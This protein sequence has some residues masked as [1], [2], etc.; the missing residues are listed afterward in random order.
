MD[1]LYLLCGATDKPFRDRE[2]R[3][4]LKHYHRT[5]SNMLNKLGS[6]ADKLFSFDDL[7]SQLK[8]FGKFAFVTGPLCIQLTLVN[9]NDVAN[10]DDIVQS[11]DT[12]ADFIAGFDAE[13]QIE[14]DKRINGLFSDLIE[15]GYFWK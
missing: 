2:Y 5:L 3:N 14:Y 4:L 8:K 12:N 10:L 11:G 6:D 13:T 15:F 7:E 1:I 9:P